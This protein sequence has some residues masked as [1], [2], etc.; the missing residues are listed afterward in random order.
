MCPTAGGRWSRQLRELERG[1]KAGP[2]KL[3]VEARW[4]RTPLK[5]EAWEAMLEGHP[6]RVLAEIV[7]RGI[8]EGF[9]VGF[10][11]NLADLQP[12]KQNLIS[13]REHPEVV[14]EYL[15]QEVMAGR[16]I[17]VGD[18]RQAQ[19]LGVHCSPFGV[20][21]KK[22][23][24]GM[25]RLIVDLSSPDGHSVNDGISRELSSL[26]YMSVDDVMAEVVRR[27]K[28]TLMAKMDIKQAYRNIPVHPV[29][30][31]LLG[32]HW[33]GRVFVDGCL[34]FGLRSAPLL[35]TAVGDLLQWVM[36]RRGVSWLSHYIDDFVTLGDPGA[37]DYRDHLQIMK[38][39]CEEAGMATEPEKG[40][41]PTTVLSFLGMELDSDQMV[42]RLPEGK[43]QLLQST[44]HS[45]RGMK[46]CKKRDLLSIIGVL[47]HACKFIRAG[48][49]FLRR[50]IDLSMGVKQLNRHVR[51]SLEARADIE[52]WYQFGRD[53]N[54]VTMMSSINKARPGAV[55]TSDASG[56]WGCG[57]WCGSHWFQLEWK[58]LGTT[59]DYGITAKELLPIVVAAAVW[60]REWQGTTVL[61]R[62]DNMAVVAIVNS[63]S[64]REREA[65]HL[66]RSLAFL[67]A[68]WSFHMFAEHI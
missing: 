43:L 52:W 27:G 30:R 24:A 37:V 15:K 44:L 36:E 28:G 18:L 56:S 6:D 8:R 48:R 5:A 23:R 59:A 63:G 3:P 12:C 1:A 55:L 60:G 25:W 2:C 51:L 42:I 13:V 53:W 22:G 61:A 49:S 65:M 50:L 9:R 26:S 68:K 66:R 58:G 16:I 35:F 39:V 34:P 14:Q 46:T 29:D 62:C 47:S 7:L 33:Q 32:M 54:G 17:E 31:V 4:I 11:G 57:A 19:A 67:E 45:W 21:P 64:S 38:A 40:E 20:I 41:G 10:H